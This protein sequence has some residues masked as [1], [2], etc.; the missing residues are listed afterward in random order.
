MFI[1]TFPLIPETLPLEEYCHISYFPEYV[2]LELYC[3]TQ[4]QYPFSADAFSWFAY[5][6]LL[7]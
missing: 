6:D 2:Q 3:A 5:Q 4:I 1:S 7:A